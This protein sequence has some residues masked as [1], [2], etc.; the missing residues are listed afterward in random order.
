MKNVFDLV[1]I[2]G[3]PSG[4]ISAG[5]A[6]TRA[7]K[8]LLLEKNKILGK[9]LLISG[10]GRCN[11]TQAEFDLHKLVS[12]YG[13]NGAFLFS[14]LHKFGPKQIM[15]FFEELGVKLEIE[16]DG[17]VF[18]VS[19]SSKE[20][21]DALKK[22]LEENSVEIKYES[23]VKNIS[24][25]N[26]LVKE[27][28]L[29]DG[30][31]ISTKNLIVATGGLSY[32]FTG[33]TGDGLVW[34]K[35]AGLEVVPLKP[36][37]VPLKIKE[38]WVKSL[39]GMVLENVGVA[40]YQNN[41]KIINK[42]GDLLFT[43]FGVSGPLVINISKSVIR[44]E[45]NG[46]VKL[47]INFF[48]GISPEQ[49]DKNLQMEFSDYSHKFLKNY[50]TEFIPKRMAECLVGILKINGDKPLHDVTREERLQLGK[51][52]NSLEITVAG[53]SGYEMAMVTSGGVSL[54][55]IDPQTMRSKKISNLY[56]VGEV[57]DLDG[58]TGGYNLQVAWATGYVAGSNLKF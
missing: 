51:L 11:I 4:M 23:I 38:A 5:M 2:G 26:S 29:T 6:A 24:V 20:V 36:A 39:P 57:L 3:G 41:K 14:A 45:K 10:N 31:K 37:L 19:N 9:K 13:E 34:A 46:E 1:V 44:A 56:F 52:L 42:T 17:R 48:P 16:N 22:Y 35:K 27:V 18:P 58:P 53:N 30:T 28:V 54:R 43:H 55:E 50:L 33:S 15:D 8:V 25:K 21:L 40:V 12:A 47:R 32:T 49:L 7:A